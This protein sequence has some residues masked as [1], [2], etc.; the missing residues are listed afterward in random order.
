MLRFKKNFKEQSLFLYP[1]PEPGGSLRGLLHITILGLPLRVK[2][3]LLFCSR[4][5]LMGHNSEVIIAVLKRSQYK[6]ISIQSPK[7]FET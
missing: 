6:E 2:V 4:M 7:L 1:L 5:S 3:V